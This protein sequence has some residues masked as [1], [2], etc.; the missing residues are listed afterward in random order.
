[1]LSAAVTGNITTPEDPLRQNGMDNEEVRRTIGKL[2][3]Q[4]QAPTV[5][6]GHQSPLNSTISSTVTP[7]LASSSK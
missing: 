2:S 1:M 5:A 3:L 6:R 4:F 7:N